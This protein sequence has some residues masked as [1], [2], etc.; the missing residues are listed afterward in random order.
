[1]AGALDFGP[2]RPVPEQSFDHSWA[3]SKNPAHTPPFSSP[4][5]FCFCF[6]GIPFVFHY[7]GKTSIPSCGLTRPAAWPALGTRQVVA[8]E[9][10]S[11]AGLLGASP[12][13]STA[14][15]VALDAR[16]LKRSEAKRSFSS[17]SDWLRC[18]FFFPQLSLKGV[19]HYVMFFFFFFFVQ[20]T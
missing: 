4:F 6:F 18:L 12:G 13:A 5:C 8:A 19:Y 10:G 15:Q 9:D 17:A 7:P 16:T 2:G 3:P 20:G 14:V 11:M 1:M